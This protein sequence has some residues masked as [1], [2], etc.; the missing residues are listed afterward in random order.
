M[1]PTLPKGFISISDAVA[2][3][4]SDTR[5][6]AKVDTKWLVNHIDWVE[7]AHNFRIPL[8]KTTDDGKISHIGDTYIQVTTTYDKEV[9]KKAIRD[10]Y[11][12]MVGHEYDAPVTR[13]V[14]TVSDEEQSGGAVRPRKTKAIAK[15]GAVIG[16]GETI[17]TNG[18]DL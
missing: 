14:S 11:R 8:L 17:K 18:A 16:T 15:E 7:E 5:A 6:N 9:I 10:H 13:A 12:E 3:I 1:Q 4:A 2:L